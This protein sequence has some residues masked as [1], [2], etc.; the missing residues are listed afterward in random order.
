MSSFNRNSISTFILGGFVT[1][2]LF[3]ALVS[4]FFQ[5]PIISSQELSKFQFLFTREQIDTVKLV[6]I[7]SSLG[8]YQ[9]ERNDLKWNLTSPR[10]IDANIN[11]IEKIL[12]SLKEI[13]IKKIYP[14]DAINLA[15]FSLDNPISTLTIKNEKNEEKS[16]S[17]GLVNP[18]DNSTYV[19][20]EDEKAIYHINNINMPFERIELASLI[21]SRIF[22]M[23]WNEIKSF[24][25]FSQNKNK[26]TLSFVREKKIWVAGNKQLHDERMKKYLSELTSLKSTII[27]DERTQK[28]DERLE[29][30]TSK[31]F[32]K[33]DVQT[34]DGN[35]IE[36]RV[37]YVISSLPGIK[38]EKKQN[39]IIKASNRQHP[40]LVNKDFMRLFY[41]R[42]SHFKPIP[43]KKLIY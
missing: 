9:L 41:R 25:L 34:E 8:E 17:F 33:L 6:K 28:L 22:N 12:S 11:M 36:Y 2:L 15:N 4:E 3:G 16:I 32:F 18:I 43:I 7:K 20:V 38:M 10:L 1:V 30:Y 19:S 24:K 29:R 40:F 37:S 42:T 21:D 13:K 26:P 23:E 27:L 5:A 39:F 31:P 35:E 14:K